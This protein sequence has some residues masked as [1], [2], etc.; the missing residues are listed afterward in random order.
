MAAISSMS[1]NKAP[2]LDGI[3][4]EFIKGAVQFYCPI[5]LEL[6]NRILSTGKYPSEWGK[7]ILQPIYKKSNKDDPINNLSW[8][9]S[10]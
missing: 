1:N 6:F 10:T 9:C 3:T 7:A 4:I 5:L 2:E 8:Y